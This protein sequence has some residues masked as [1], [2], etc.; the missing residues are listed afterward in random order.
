MS[1]SY[2]QHLR[3]SAL[4]AVLASVA[5]VTLL[6]GAYF[7]AEPSISHGQSDTKTFYVRQTI[8]DESS[9][10]TYPTSVS[11]VG[12]VYGVTGG[13]AT[14]TAQFVVVSNNSA[15]Y[16]VTIDFFDNGTDGAMLGDI[17]DDESIRNY[18]A[19]TATPSY[20]W[21]ASTA[22]QFAYT[23]TST[24]SADTGP[25][26]LNNGSNACG[27]GATQTEATCWMTPSTSEIT[28]VDTDGPALT[29]ATSTLL[30]RVEVPS[31]AVPAPQAETYTATATL[32]LYVK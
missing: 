1:N 8:S 3:Q 25:L 14:G 2:L 15:G 5:V 27:V 13:Q 6:F 22:A 28:I 21:T 9:F 11:M 16:Y 31:G 18:S 26:F 23:I 10:T 32:S 20:G 30:F 24:S 29:G 7:L 17:T 19:A 12:T 4:Y